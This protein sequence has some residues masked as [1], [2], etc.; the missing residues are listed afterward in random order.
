M[1]FISIPSIPIYINL[2]LFKENSMKSLNRRA[3]WLTTTSKRNKTPNL[4]SQLKPR[5]Q[6]LVVLF[7]VLE[8]SVTLAGQ[9]CINPYVPLHSLSWWRVESYCINN[10][11]INVTLAYMYAW[12]TQPKQAKYIF[13][14]FMKYKHRKLIISKINATNIVYMY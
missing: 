6:F 2:K 4:K 12:P 7:V 3:L 1:Y 11:S 13:N 14:I 9:S 5:R 8:A 10:L